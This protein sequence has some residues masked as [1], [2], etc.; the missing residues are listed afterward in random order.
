M[1][2][3]S[4]Q[5]FAKLRWLDS[6]PL[7]PRIEEYR[8]RI[9][10]R[11]LD[12]TLYNL[13]LAGRAKKNAKTLDLVL[14]ALYSLICRESP[15]G[16]QCYILANDSEQAG[17]DLDLAKKL[18]GVNPLLERHLTI[19]LKS[20]VRKDGR[21]Q[22]DILPAGDIAGSHGKTYVFCGFDEIH[23][24][25]SWDILE[26]LQ[27]DP[28]RRD[29]LM[30]IT[31]Y[32]SLYHK[33]GV[34]LYDLMA[35]GKAGSDSRML[36]SWYAADYTTDDDL[37][38]GGTAEE[39]ANPSR[40]SWE[41]QGYL[42]QQQ[43]R[44]PSH[45]YRRLH[46]NLPGLPEGSAYQ[47]E[48]LLDAIARGC[49]HRPPE[50]GVVYFAFVDMSGGSNDDATLGISHL[51][52]TGHAILDV[53]TNQGSRPPFDPRA[54]VS[55]FADLAKQYGVR[56]VYGDNYAGHTFAADFANHGLGYEPSLSSASE[57][58]EAFE[59]ALN[60]RRVSLLDQPLLESQLLGLS[61]RGG[62]ITHPNGEHDDWC[63]A[64]VGALL[65]ALDQPSGAADSGNLEDDLDDNIV[66]SET[67]GN[68]LQG[69]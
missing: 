54:A 64:A 5:F 6:T 27:G 56:T 19:K 48:P 2:L 60:S 42:E 10:A 4:L 8:Q 21:G 1:K 33:P 67:G 68:F 61:W 11:A 29:A 52:P 47:L 55:R 26:A 59:V 57:L 69:W 37:D 32:A 7:L 24:Y 62:K 51:D 46:L 36:F 9:F 35:A 40:G 66:A 45:Q 65:V 63:N 44:L 3:T 34:P 28:T 13:V 14:A 16:S 49:R 41:D 22:L 18:I 43:R 39:K 38:L 25:K 20:I 15:Q 23:A 30:W 53:V 31:S 50:P 58:Y 17:D 12:S